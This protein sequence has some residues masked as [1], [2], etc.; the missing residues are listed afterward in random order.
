M[1]TRQYQLE[2]IMDKVAPDRLWRKLSTESGL[3]EWI[4]GEVKFEQ[5]QATFH[6]EAC[7]S[8][9]ANI[10]YPDKWQIRFN[11]VDEDEYIGFEVK[12][13][14]LTQDAIL[15]ITDF[16]DEGSESA[17]AE[18]WEPQVTDLRRILGLR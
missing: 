12:V 4:T 16:S 5:E 15:V 13:T 14:D 9:V 2:Y 7:A 8:A 1:A 17:I 11:W 10:E 3:N 18:I 6:W